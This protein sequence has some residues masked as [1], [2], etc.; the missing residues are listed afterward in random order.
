MPP[1]G[2]YAA[3]LDGA[4][5]AA[6]SWEG[7]WGWCLGLTTGNEPGQETWDRLPTPTV[8][9]Y[10]TSGKFLFLG[11]LVLSSDKGG[12]TGPCKGP[13]ALQ[14]LLCRASGQNLREVAPGTEGGGP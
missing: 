6:A 4:Q 12:W 1:R 13:S 7:T 14:V 8:T 2:P 5:E 9:Y 11:S 3:L 10:V